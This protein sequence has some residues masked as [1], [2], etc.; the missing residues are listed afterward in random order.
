MLLKCTQLTNAEW[1]FP[2]AKGNDCVVVLGDK[3]S[4]S[5][6]KAENI[7]KKHLEVSPSSNSWSSFKRQVGSRT[8]YSVQKLVV[9]LNFMHESTMQL[10]L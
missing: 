3:I 7:E 10:L 5:S 9:W 8:R 2:L 1:Q 6:A 4:Y